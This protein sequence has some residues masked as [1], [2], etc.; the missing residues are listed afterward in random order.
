[1]ESSVESSEV[2][3]KVFPSSVSALTW[4]ELSVVLE[5]N[6]TVGLSVAGTA[7]PGW[8]TVKNTAAKTAPAI[9]KTIPATAAITNGLLVCHNKANLAPNPGYVFISSLNKFELYYIFLWLNLN[10][11]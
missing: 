5:A 11:N 1:M 6:W 3:G 10:K 9:V 7:W 4:A 8:I 2:S